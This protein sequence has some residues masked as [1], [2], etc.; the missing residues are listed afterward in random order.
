MLA[1]SLENVCGGVYFSEVAA[2]DPTNLVKDK[3]R[4]WYIPKILPRL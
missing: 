3:L 2:L 4:K 1:K